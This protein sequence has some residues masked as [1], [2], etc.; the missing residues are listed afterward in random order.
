MVTQ[1]V[2]SPG[3]TAP[4]IQRTLDGC[5]T[6][7]PSHTGHAAPSPGARAGVRGT[8]NG[9]CKLLT[10]QYENRQKQNKTYLQKCLNDVRKMLV[11]L[12]YC[13]INYCM[14]PT[15]LSHLPAS[16][17]QGPGVGQ[18]VFC[19]GPHRQSLEDGLSSD[20]Q[21]LCSGSSPGSVCW[22]SSFP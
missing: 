15:Q 7:T 18:L 20:S 1:L 17:S 14:L 19:P 10:E 5:Y 6:V 2:S 13:C 3:R 4:R 21:Q 22:Q 12:L 9:I 16:T 11:S 8:T